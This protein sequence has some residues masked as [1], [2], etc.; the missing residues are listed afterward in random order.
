MQTPNDFH[1]D[2][3]LTNFISGYDN[4]DY[5]MVARTAFTVIPVEHKSDI[6]M[7]IDKGAWF[8]DEMGVRPMG[9]ASRLATF[10]TSTG[11]YNAQEWGLRHMVDDRVKANNNSPLVYDESASAFLERRTSSAR[12]ATSPSTSSRR[13]CGARTWRA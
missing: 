13:A 2:Q 3:Y 5:A 10:S 1:V 4:R 12:T 7:K 9:G 6:Y 8:R 11:T